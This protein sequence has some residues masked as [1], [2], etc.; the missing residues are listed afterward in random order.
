MHGFHGPKCTHRHEHRGRDVTVVR[1]EHTGPGVG[2]GVVGEKVEFHRAA[3]VEGRRGAHPRMGRMAVERPSRDLIRRSR[4]WVRLPA[5]SGLGFSIRRIQQPL[6]GSSSSSVDALNL[7]LI[8]LWAVTSADRGWPSSVIASP[9]FPIGA[10]HNWIQNFPTRA[11][12]PGSFA[13]DPEHCASG[14]QHV[15]R[16]VLR[17]GRCARR[18]AVLPS[19]DV[20]PVGLPQ[21]VGGAGPGPTDQRGDLRP[22]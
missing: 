5:H 18:A 8:C 11:W 14:L 21:A 3:K 6:G 1:V 2:C 22:Q 17:H 4:R 9:A 19:G 12:V 10:V 7:T 13:L 20:R 15:V 16:R